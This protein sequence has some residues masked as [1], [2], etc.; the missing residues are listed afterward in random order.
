MRSIVRSVSK[1]V[2][3]G[4]AKCAH[5]SAVIVGSKFCRMYSAAETRNP[6]VPQ[7]GS[8]ITS[9][10][11]GRSKATIIS[12]ICFGVRNCP[13]CPA[14][15]SLLSI[16]SYKSPCISNPVRSCS[17]KS[18]SP[19]I[20]FCKTCGVGIKNIASLIYLAKAVSVAE[21]SGVCGSII[22][23]CAVKSGKQPFFIF[24]IARKTL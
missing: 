7:A 22:S 8:Q 15:A 4:P 14:V 10:G 11:V 19:V 18:S 12:R 2:N 21:S 16:Y 13:F 9:S 24:L 1:P 23:P 20:I 6:A 3:A 17:Y 5:C